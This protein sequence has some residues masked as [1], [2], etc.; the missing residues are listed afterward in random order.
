MPCFGKSSTTDDDA[1]VHRLHDI[2]LERDALK[3]KEAASAKEVARLSALVE[4]QTKKPTATTKGAKV[5]SPKKEKKDAAK[6]VE[7]EDV[8]LTETGM[9]AAVSAFVLKKFKPTSAADRTMSVLKMAALFANATVLLATAAETMANQREEE[10]GAGGVVGQPSRAEMQ[11]TIEKLGAVST[12]LGQQTTTVFDIQCSLDA[13]KEAHAEASDENDQFNE[14]PKDYIQRD[15]IKPKEAE[16]AAALAVRDKTQL[17]L[18]TMRS[19]AG[20]SVMV[21]AKAGEAQYDAAWA[22]QLTSTGGAAAATSIVSIADTLVAAAPKPAAAGQKAAMQP[23]GST[24]PFMQRTGLVVIQQLFALL[25][26]AVKAKLINSTGSKCCLVFK[27]AARAFEK[28][29]LRWAGDPRCVTDYGRS[30]L[31]AQNL[32]DLLQM[33]ELVRIVCETN[34]YTITSCKNSLDAAKEVIG[35]GYRNLMLTIRDAATQHIVELQLNLASIEAVKG[36]P[37][38]HIV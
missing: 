23:A 26:A 1:L 32:P 12:V 16:L 17:Q 11:L 4:G 28:V 35:V 19:E 10:D 2:T 8:F 36:S 22:E 29:L 14:S 9:V 5:K 15:Q 7:E 34:G 3:K 37:C 18:S 13:A 6:G 24:I 31:V 27:A 33:L 38:G 30:T 25:L 20:T 21:L